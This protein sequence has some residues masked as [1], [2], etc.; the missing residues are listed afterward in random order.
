MKIFKNPVLFKKYCLSLKKKGP[1]GF[2]PTMG[3]L[4]EG[5]LSLIRK[6]RQHCRHTVVSIFV[7][8]LQFGPKEDFHAYPRPLKADL[9]RC[10][11]EKTDAVFIPEPERFYGPDFSIRIDETRISQGCCGAFRPGHFSGVLT[12]MA[13]LLN[14]TQPDFLFMGQKDYQQCL[15][16]KRLITNLNFPVKLIMCPTVRE[17]SGMAMSSRNKYLSPEEKLFA[18]RIYAALKKTRELSGQNKKPHNHREWS[19]L[20]K[21]LF[22]RLRQI[23]SFVP[24]YAVIGNAQNLELPDEKTKNA[25]ALTAG[26]FGKTRLIDNILL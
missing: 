15:V 9:A 19:A 13:K 14:C 11:S 6:A 18:A 21:W 17:Q 1:L 8:P 23:E 24:Q 10:R 12:V 16:I 26:F 2:V 3:C 20:Q 4:H 25:V 22:D 5:H 7:N